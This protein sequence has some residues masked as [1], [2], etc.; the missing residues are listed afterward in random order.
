MVRS[1]DKRNEKGYSGGNESKVLVRDEFDEVVWEV[2]GNISFYYLVFVFNG[3]G[4]GLFI[5]VEV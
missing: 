3:I 1:I 4:I 5:V 2:G